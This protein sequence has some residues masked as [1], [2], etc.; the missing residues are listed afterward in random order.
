MLY[1]IAIL[2]LIEYGNITNSLIPKLQYKKLQRLQNRALKIIYANTSSSSIEDF[3][4]KACLAPIAQR[5][6]RQLICLMYKRSL[7]PDIYP[8]VDTNTDT[9]A[10]EQIRFAIPGPNFEKLKK[11]PMYKGAKLLNTLPATT[12]KLQTYELFKSCI[13]KTANFIDYPVTG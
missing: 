12:K 13:P 9:R 7:M 4:L 5:A 11:F 2:P 3:H 10:N 8:Q 1:K 6:D